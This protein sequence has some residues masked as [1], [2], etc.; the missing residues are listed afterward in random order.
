MGPR[1]AVQRGAARGCI[2]HA[3]TWQQHFNGPMPQLVLR[4][5][6]CKA[7]APL[8]TL[9]QRA[10]YLRGAQLVQAIYSCPTHST[11][12]S[13]QPCSSATLCLAG[14]RLTHCVVGSAAALDCGSL[15]VFLLFAF[16]SSSVCKSIF[17]RGILLHGEKSWE[18]NVLAGGA[19]ARCVCV[20]GGG[21]EGGAT[22]SAIAGRVSRRR[23]ALN[24][25][26]RAQVG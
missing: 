16:P 24:A 17:G 18:K 1:G 6:A 12:N 5:V 3:P 26:D 4:R 22:R 19:G 21:Q 2:Q 25:I 10:T 11:S 9:W 13:V 14:L 20:G 15:V 23:G 8:E 7:V